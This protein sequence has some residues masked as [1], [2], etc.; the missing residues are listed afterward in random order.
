MQTP[1][2]GKLSR[3]MQKERELSLNVE[4]R[5]K[6]YGRLSWNSRNL[7]AKGNTKSPLKSLPSHN[8]QNNTTFLNSLSDLL[9]LLGRGEERLLPKLLNFLI[10]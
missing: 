10:S 7:T 8:L 6:S 4:K 3:K 2:T 1:V 9:L 5:Q